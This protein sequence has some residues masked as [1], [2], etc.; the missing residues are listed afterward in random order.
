MDLLTISYQ[1]HVSYSERSGV[2]GKHNY[3]RIIYLTKGGGGAHMGS[4]PERVL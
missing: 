3:L 2:V 4:K 1:L